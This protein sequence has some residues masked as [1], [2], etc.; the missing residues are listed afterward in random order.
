MHQYKAPQCLIGLYDTWSCLPATP[1]T[2]KWLMKQGHV[3]LSET[4]T[5][6]KGPCTALTF[7]DLPPC[8]RINENFPK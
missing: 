4:H 7:L 1:E 8:E 6:T 2:V 3:S 5:P